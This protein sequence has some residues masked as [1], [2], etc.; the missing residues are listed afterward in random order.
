MTRVGGKPAERDQPG[1]ELLALVTGGLPLGAAAR[2]L[3]AIRD[4]FGAGSPVP[5]VAWAVRGGVA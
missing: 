5:V 4:Q 3:K 2:R 1:V